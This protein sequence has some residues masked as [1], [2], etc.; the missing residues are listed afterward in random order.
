MREIEIERDGVNS[1]A[2][3][4]GRMRATRWGK[5]GGSQARA[6]Q[7]PTDREARTSGGG[8]TPTAHDSRW[9]DR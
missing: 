7:P 4:N 3:W 2:R 5:E 6:R 1:R 8:A 9:M